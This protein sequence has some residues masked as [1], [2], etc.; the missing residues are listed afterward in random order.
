MAKRVEQTELQFTVTIN[1]ERKVLK[2]MKEIRAERRTLIKQLDTQQLTQAEYNKKVN[3]LSKL[4]GILADHRKKIRGVGDS[5][6]GIKGIISKI[7]PTLIASFSIGAIVRFGEQLVQSG[8]EMEALDQ[9]ANV[10]FGNAIEYVNRFA[11]ENAKAMGLTRR[12]YVA[13]A[14]GA[15]DLLIPIGFQREKAAQLSSELVNLSG[16]LSEWTGGQVDSA[17]VSNILTKA[18]LGERE[19]LKTL[20]IAINEAD[21][22]AKLALK[23]QEKLTGEALKQ[24]K[25]LATLELITA[26]SGDAQTKFANNSASAA[27]Q[28]SQI[29]AVLKEAGENITKFFLP[30]VSK[31]LGFISKLVGGTTRY[32]DKLDE[33]RISLNKLVI[34]INS[35]NENEE[36]RSKLISTLQSQYPDFLQNLNAETV[37]NGQLQARLKEVN[38]ELVNKIILQKEDEKVQ[39][40]LNAVVDKKTKALERE[41]DLLTE[42]QALAEKYNITLSEQGDLQAKAQELLSQ[43]PEGGLAGFDR[44]SL[45]KAIDNYEITQTF[46]EGSN[47]FLEDLTKKREELAKRLGLATEA[48]VENTPAP[49]ITTPTPTGSSGSRNN[50]LQLLREA[51]KKLEDLKLELLEDGLE[52]EIA[53]IELSAQREL[54]TVKGSEEQQA[55]IRKLI[56]ERTEKQISLIKAQ[57]QRE[58]EERLLALQPDSIEKEIA[59]IQLKAQR[60]IEEVKGTTEQKETIKT[61]IIARTEKEIEAI[62]EKYR[63]K[64]ITEEQKRIK[65]QEELLQELEK[66]N[67]D[68]L[69]NQ[70]QDLDEH[71]RE[72][73]ALVIQNVEAEVANGTIQIA[74]VEKALRERMQAELIAYLEERKRI[75]EAAG[76]DTTDI[77]L[78]LDKLNLDGLIS[79]ADEAGA[80]MN[81][82]W[83]NI[84]AGADIAAQALNSLTAIQEARIEKAYNNQVSSLE[85]AQEREIKAAGNNAAVKEQIEEKYQQKRESIELEYRK[86]QQKLAITQAIIDV[87]AGTVKA[88]ASGPVVPNIPAG[89]IFAALGSLQIAAIKAQQFA[90]GGV[91]PG[92]GGMANGPSHTQGGILL[93]DSNSG[94]VKGEIEGGEPIYSKATYANNRQIMDQL[95]YVSTR[96]GGRQLK[97]HEIGYVRPMYET[98]GIL[99]GPST[100]LSQQTTEEVSANPEQSALSAQIAGLT[101]AYREGK[102]IVMGEREFALIGEGLDKIDENRQRRSLG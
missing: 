94:Q 52:K 73:Q 51:Q 47:R 4:N 77:Q 89:I 84:S 97:P 93:V 61:L 1:G 56:A 79:S 16:A 19:Q 85:D 5:L 14:A 40:Q 82:L 48:A 9:K 18:L 86:K 76:E 54:E 75:L 23:G 60:E 63:L 78:Q 72:R 99:D 66:V 57:Y 15:A 71:Y 41:N 11:D 59:I 6:S 30:A 69:K 64:E 53:L 70:L 43:L 33:Q 12:E 83:G 67:E 45:T 87:A 92:K 101:A 3:E 50:E 8:V 28:L 80:K 2:T 96:E 88:L 81:D 42:T 98:G 32:S 35:T 90:D 68:A 13:A 20:G 46:L 34:S 91:L 29:R 74:D 36:K 31:S 7:G 37:T 65:S 55:E 27:R 95:L 25:A 39:D 100:T 10:V 102:I 21:V 44:R 22:K 17:E 38:A 58:N 26:K 62:R 49:T 24:A